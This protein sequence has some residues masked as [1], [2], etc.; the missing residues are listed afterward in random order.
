MFILTF[1]K[2]NIKFGATEGLHTVHQIAMPA[3]SYQIDQWLGNAPWRWRPKI[4]LNSSPTPFLGAW[5]TS[6][7]DILLQSLLNLACWSCSTLY[8]QLKI[9][10]DSLYPF[11]MRSSTK[12]KLQ[13]SKR[14]RVKANAPTTLGQELRCPLRGKALPAPGLLDVDQGKVDHSPVAG[15]GASDRHTPMG[16]KCGSDSYSCPYFPP[17]PLS[18]TPMSFFW[19]LPPHP[20]HLNPQPSPRVP[21]YS[22]TPITP[23]SQRPF[24]HVVYFLLKKQS[25]YLWIILLY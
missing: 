12:L 7:L 6:L 20:H 15:M 22:S 4:Q 2:L 3:D 13:N 1:A 25:K 5:P 17:D 19:V 24:A 11:R 9:P 18:L 21:T 23:P 16:G 8:R 10:R 14:Y